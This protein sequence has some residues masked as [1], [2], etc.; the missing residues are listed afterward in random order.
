M[1]PQS[2]ENVESIGKEYI[3]F[4]AS[5][6]APVAISIQE[7]EKESSVDP[8]LSQLRKCVLSENWNHIP[9]GYKHVRFELAVLGQLV[10]RGNCIVVPKK[11]RPQVVNLAHE[12]H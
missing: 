1:I 11:L 9:E 6:A 10:L 3:R 12:G 7:V 5:N 2:S 8:E 4:V